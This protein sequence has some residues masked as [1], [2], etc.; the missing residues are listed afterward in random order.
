MWSLQERYIRISAAERLTN[1]HDVLYDR[2]PPGKIVGF[3]LGTVPSA[4]FA[5]EQAGLEEEK[6]IM[7]KIRS[8]T[9]WHRNETRRFQTCLLHV[10]LWWSA[11]PALSSWGWTLVH[12]QS[13]RAGWVCLSSRLLFLLAEKYSLRLNSFV[14]TV[15]VSWV[16]KN[17]N[18]LGWKCRAAQ[19]WSSLGCCTGGAVQAA[20][21]S[22]DP[23]PLDPPHRSPLPGPAETVLAGLKLFYRLT[24]TTIQTKS[25]DSAKKWSDV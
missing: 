25:I 2:C 9:T 10:L 14:F 5:W 4:R 1:L 22:L 11:L 12:L 18:L 20:G 3:V 16:K 19:L 13:S 17:V 24:S 21:S 7:S 23:S 15:N 6:V 8:K